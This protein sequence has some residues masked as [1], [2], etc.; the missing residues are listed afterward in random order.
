[1]KTLFAAL[2]L[3]LLPFATGA[4]DLAP[5]T[6][7]LA[8]IRVHIQAELSGLPNYTCLQTVTRFH[9][10]DARAKFL[11]LDRVM[12]ELV[13]SGHREWFGAPG[14]GALSEQNPAHFT[15]S[16]MIG[17]GL[18]AITLYN[19][20]V[21]DSARLT[22]Q[23]EETLEGRRVVR[24]DFVLPRVVNGLEVSVPGGIGIVGEEGSAW[25]D[26]ATLD[27][28]RLESRVIEIPAFLP[29]A[30]LELQVYYARTR[31]GEHDS[32]LAQQSDLTM[33]LPTGV[34]DFDHF[35]FTHCR[36]F[37][38]TSAIHFDAAA[39]AAAPDPDPKLKP[40]AEPK[41]PSL[42]AVTVALTTPVTELNAVGQRIQGRVVGAVKHKGRIVLEDGAAV[43]GRIR[44]LERYR[45]GSRYIV[46]LE[47]TEV[48]V[49][50]TAVRFYADLL[51]L[52]KRKGIEPMVREMVFR[53]G[54]AEP[55]E[56]TIPELPGVASFFVEGKTFTLPEGFQTTWRTRGIL[57]GVN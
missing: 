27:P 23:G 19:V 26:P 46:G 17:N 2:I 39:P 40:E 31:I 13:Y 50:E 22:W 57:N 30:A 38:T 35:D 32:L 33:V 6:L 29:L 25:I 3:C 18:F 34:A 20:F 47:L 24:Y 56:V 14:G 48:D 43:R 53:W 9:K 7:L 51:S 12:L 8:R 42:L 28:V 1:M 52:Q 4:Q 44:R 45:D 55:V 36:M 49:G 16:G 11:P 37:H 41:I 15:G 10:A 54:K 21:S 5:E